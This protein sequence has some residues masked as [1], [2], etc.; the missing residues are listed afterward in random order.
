MY[1]TLIEKLEDERSELDEKIARLDTFLKGPRNSDLPDTYYNKMRD[2]HFAMQRYSSCLNIRA[3]ILRTAQS[4][5]E[6]QEL[7]A[8]A[9]VHHATKDE[10]TA[11]L[12]GEGVTVEGPNGSWYTITHDNGSVTKV[13]GEDEAKELAADW[14]KE[15]P[16]PPKPV[17]GNE[18][19]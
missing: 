12:T 5:A 13:Q 9:K 3:N 7:D 10:E 14:R 18:V 8:N 11:W 16:E 4:I 6:G 15:A 17:E 1:D 2:Q 19:I